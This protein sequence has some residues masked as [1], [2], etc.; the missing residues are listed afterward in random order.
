MSAAK[1]SP[2]DPRWK[3]ASVA[4]L[5]AGPL[6]QREA[7]IAG[8]CVC[9]TCLS[10]I[11]TCERAVMID[12]P[13]GPRV[14]V[15]PCDPA[16]T[17][18]KMEDAMKNDASE[19]D[20]VTLA[21]AKNEKKMREAW[22]APAV[23]RADARA[24]TR[25]ND[26]PATLTSEIDD[27]LA[28]GGLTLE[29]LAE[30]DGLV[31]AAKARVAENARSN[32]E[33]MTDAPNLTAD[34]VAHAEKALETAQQEL[35]RAQDLVEGNRTDASDRISVATARQHRAAAVAWKPPAERRLDAVRMDVTDAYDP[36]ATARTRRDH[37]A[38]TAWQRTDPQVD[39]LRTDAIR[40][41]LRE[42][43]DPIAEAKHRQA[44]AATN[45]WR[46]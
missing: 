8:A 39:D 21:Y 37:A 31:T 30:L 2:L 15:S 22:H 38:A 7:Y 11:R 44:L 43:N 5:D 35:E 16:V 10:G 3:E 29:R 4:R 25:Y 27:L 32:V 12:S 34:D 6:N 46:T 41:Y 45:A 23:V 20:P 24:R 9:A 26:T 19:N 1:I 18:T 13:H 14:S 17:T 40:P 28:H 42:S 36:I 33:A